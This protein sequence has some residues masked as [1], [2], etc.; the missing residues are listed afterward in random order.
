MTKI[1]KKN[2]MAVMWLF[3]LL[4]T[5]F[6][7]QATP[8]AEP[9]VHEVDVCIYGGTASGVIAAYSVKMLG[10]SVLLVEPGKYLGGMTTGGLGSTDVGHKEAITGL[11]RLFYRRIG[12]HYNKFEEWSFP[13][14]VASKVINQFVTDGGFETIYNR[15]IIAATTVNTNITEI[16]LEDSNTPATSPL[17]K[18]KAKVFIDCSYEGDLMAKSGVSYFVGREDNSMFGETLNGVQLAYYHQ[19]PDG[20]DPYKIEGDPSS[21]LCWGIS[22]E[23]FGTEGTGDKSIQAY[24]FRLCLTKEESNRR[25]FERPETYNRDYYELLARTFKKMDSNINRYLL[26]NGLMDN[27]YDVNN[28][29]P[30]STNMLGMNHEYP[31][32]SYEK[33]AEIWD[34]HKEYLKGYLY[35]L[36]TDESVPA[37]LRT[38][39]NKWGWA[40][41]EFIDN[42]NFPTQLYIREARR[43]HGE[44]VMT[45]KNCQGVEVVEDKVGM[46]SYAMDS[47]NCR[48]VVVNGMVKNEGDVQVILSN[49]YPISYRSITPKR[50]ECE[51][52]LVPVCVSSSHIAYGSIRMEPV[53]MILG[54][55]AAVA[56]S[57]AIDGNVPVQEINVQDLMK[58]LEEDP[59]LNGTPPEEIVGEGTPENPYLI[60]NKYQLAQVNNNISAHF[61]M[62]ED[63][64]LTGEAW[65][66]IGGISK[67]FKG[68]FDGNG[69]TIIGANIINPGAWSGFFGV[70]DGGT[71]KNLWLKDISVTAGGESVGAMVGYI[72]NGTINNCA[73]TGTINGGTYNNIGGLVGLVGGGTNVTISNCYLDVQVSGNKSVAGIIGA[74]TSPV[75]VE[76]CVMSGKITSADRAAAVVGIAKSTP[77][78]YKSIVAPNLS[79]EYS[80]SGTTVDFNRIIG[81]TS[82]PADYDN[83]LAGELVQ[84]INV[85]DKV[86]TSALNSKDGLTTSDA[87]LKKQITYE[88]IGFDFGNTENAPW[89]IETDQYPYLVFMSDTAVFIP[90]DDNDE[91]DVPV[92]GYTGEGDGT[93]SSPFLIT[94]VNELNQVNEYRSAHFKQMNDID[95]S[96]VSGWTR[97]GSITSPFSGT[98]D[99]NGHTISNLKLSSGAWTGFFGTV[100]GATI[101]NI[102][103]KNVTVTV[104]GENGGGLIGY[105]LNGT[106]KNCAV[107]GSITGGTNNNIGGL[108]GLVSGGTGVTISDCYIDMEA[109]GNRSIA[110]VVGAV[111]SP[112]SV[113]RCVVSGKIV[114]PDRAAAAVGIT[115]AA[116]C[117]YNSI[118]ALNLDIEYPGTGAMTDFNRIVGNV[119]TPAV[120]NNNLAGESVRFLNVTGKVISSGLDSKD[121]LTK[122]DAELKQQITYEQIGYTFG[123]QENSPW[124]MSQ[125]STTPTLWFVESGP[126]N[127]LNKLSQNTIDV[128]PN[129]FKD[130]IHIKNL[131]NSPI[132]LYSLSG[133]CMGVFNSSVVSLGYLPNGVYT[134]KTKDNTGTCFQKIIK[135]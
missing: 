80:G 133:V 103:L 26:I 100:D 5:T 56:A 33:R 46:A 36:S 86:I 83:N 85:P 109:C 35:F 106:V 98:F 123:N 117:S 101:K 51:N 20:V 102:F 44:Y 28:R 121:G 84:F 108:I 116:S 131:N 72:L 79:L 114:S 2:G 120:Y 4:F 65:S 63:V 69:K 6:W 75:K 10:K 66:K 68:V 53:F 54:Q 59:Y 29:G 107:T 17:V 62:V 14:S 105:I 89:K 38:E 48:R 77:A 43:L 111:T 37:D 15:R 87:N 1:K 88:N 24:N 81:N 9:A 92:D 30:L 23:P 27:K 95:L 13:P 8:K 124:S 11:S 125:T 78:S 67:K 57:M 130:V 7:L 16:E 134:L 3:S 55:S 32:G 113:D 22:D 99:G 97:I 12:Q 21:G 132:E 64:D 126:V 93:A 34:A 25:P 90:G 135:Y 129:P 41:D 76:H 61:K 82:S 118:V 58:K 104:T 94:N 128:F 60:S 40:K 71:V 19:F 47:H 50:E 52:L 127:S 96:G 39:V 45:Q 74:A 112:V 73:V 119:S 91:P 42:D 49:P 122:T 31:E 18:V 110:G 70:I 115:K